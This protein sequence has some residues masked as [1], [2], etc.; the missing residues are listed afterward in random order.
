[1]TGSLDKLASRYAAV[2]LN[3]THRQE[4]IS[5]VKAMA[6]QLLKAYRTATHGVLPQRI[7]YLRDGVD[8]GHYAEIIRH[9]MIGIRQAAKA[10]LG[11][12]KQPKITVIICRKRH[13]TRFFNAR[14]SRKRLR[15]GTVIDTDV[16][17]PVEWDF[18]KSV[19]SIADKES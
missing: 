8:E 10:V 15:P 18:C 11:D 2:A 4:T 7:I 17:H 3:Q 16:T 9:E 5:D 12:A 6:T 14:D 19:P 13:H 1:M